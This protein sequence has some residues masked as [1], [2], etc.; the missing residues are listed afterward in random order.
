MNAFL[1][2]DKPVGITSHDVVARVRRLLKQRK[3]GHTGTLDPFATGVLP[4][5]VGEATKAIQY[6]D[7]SVKEYRAT[8]L[9]GTA[10]DTQDCTGT[11]ISERDWSSVTPEQISETAAAFVGEILQLPPMFSALKR[12]GIPL[13]RL[14]RRGE[15]VEREARKVTVHGLVLDSIRLPEV[16]F[17]VRCSRG[18]YV[19]TLATDIGERLGCGAHLTELQRTASGI[20]TLDRAVAADEISVSAM[21]ARSV[22]IDEALS[23]IP[24]VPLDADLTRRAM[25]GMA[26][27][28]PAPY[29]ATEGTVRLTF[30]G[31]IVAV[32][33]SSSEEGRLVCRPERVF[34]T[35][36]FT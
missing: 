36:S 32:A 12:D 4:V 5:A 20:F 8:M 30:D 13:Y 11:S 26:V 14:A 29:P 3:A 31:R 15:E 19:R 6:L 22:T 1:I 18:T 24:E 23:H 35:F 10:T 28:V 25:H 17:T 27:T 9:L 2:V 7:E 16:R 33:R 34:T 21:E